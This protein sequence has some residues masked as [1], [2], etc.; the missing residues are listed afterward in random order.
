LED[1]GLAPQDARKFGVLVSP[2]PGGN[3]LTSY[4]LTLLKVLV[5]LSPG[6]LRPDTEDIVGPIGP[7]PEGPCD[8]RP[9]WSS[10][11][12]EKRTATPRG[13]Q[14]EI[15]RQARHMIR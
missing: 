7:D 13:K 9:A 4:W 5:L 12:G 15:C 10:S 6:D 1:R 8:L 11:A 2:L 3:R 14:I